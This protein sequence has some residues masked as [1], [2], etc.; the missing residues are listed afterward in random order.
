MHTADNKAYLASVLHT[1]AQIQPSA[2]LR[3]CW[4]RHVKFSLATLITMFCEEV[5][6]EN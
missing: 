2:G 5:D 3:M 1:F 6:Y 4:N